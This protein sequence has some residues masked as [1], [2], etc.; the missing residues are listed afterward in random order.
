MSLRGLAQAEVYEKMGS[1][2]VDSRIV[3]AASLATTAKLAAQAKPT[4]SAAAA[5]NDEV[6]YYYLSV[7]SE[8]HPEPTLKRYR[9]TFS[10]AILV[11]VAL[12]DKPQ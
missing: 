10:R 3:P 2:P 4:P 9:F 6:A 11:S 7:D 5:P 1:T 12:E 8:H